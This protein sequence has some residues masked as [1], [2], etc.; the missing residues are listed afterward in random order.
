M[1]D[2]T[3]VEILLAGPTVD[4]YIEQWEPRIV[5]DATKKQLYRL[6]SNTWAVR[7]KSLFVKNAENM[8]KGVFHGAHETVGKEYDIPLGIFM[9]TSNRR[10]SMTV[11]L[12][13]EKRKPAL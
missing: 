11:D 9:M 3:I 1:E 13:V 5:T 7:V 12:T 2:N 8:P 6:Q 4:G 10:S